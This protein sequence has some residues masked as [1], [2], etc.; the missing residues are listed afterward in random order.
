ML[1]VVHGIGQSYAAKKEQEREME[2]LAEQE[3]LAAE[4]E[5]KK[6]MNTAEIQK[7]AAL[8]K[9][10][11][12]RAGKVATARSQASNFITQDDS[13]NDLYKGLTDNQKRWYR[14]PSFVIFMILN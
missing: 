14:I 7:A 12:E 13:I 4:R 5:N 9:K 8:Q 6:A 11:Q 10:M 2:L 1:G 3:R